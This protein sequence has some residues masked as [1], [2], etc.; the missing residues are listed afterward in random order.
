MHSIDVITF[1]EAMAMFIA[2]SCGPLHEI[3]HFTMELAGAETNVAIGLA[4]LGY[5]ASFVSKVG[6]DAFGKF[7]MEKLQKHQVQVD[8]IITDTQFPTGF[9]LKSRVTEG[10]PEVQYFRKGSAA[11]HLAI[12]DFS[13]HYFQKAKHLHMTGIPLA[14]SSDTRNF[15]QHALSFFKNKAKKISFDPNLRPRLWNSEKEMVDT[16]NFFAK[17]ANYVLP[18]L[19]EGCKLTGFKTPSDIASY[20]LDAGVEL[21]IIKLGEQ[22]AYFKS[23]KQEGII[24][25][26]PVEKVIDTVGAGD[27]FAVGVI[28]GLLE[29]LPVEE[30]VQRGNAIGAL[31]VQSLGDNTGYPDMQELMHFINNQSQRSVRI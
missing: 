17:Q 13:E 18:G 2:D 24:N 10:D 21:V 28:S 25:G 20:Y 31:A 14:L 23:S 15:A 19:E 11:S 30:S 5:N 22:G 8:Q 26:Y 6:A 29:G 27:G 16:I 1:G 7:I 4:K 12:S 3:N 9:Q